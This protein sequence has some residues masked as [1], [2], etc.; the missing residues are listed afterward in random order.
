METSYIVETMMPMKRLRIV[1]MAIMMK[2][3]TAGWNR[4]CG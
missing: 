1:K 2:G 3:S 4:G